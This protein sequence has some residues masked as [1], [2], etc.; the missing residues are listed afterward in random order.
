MCLYFSSHVVYSPAPQFFLSQLQS[1]YH[2]HHSNTAVLV[3]ITSDSY[4]AEATFTSKPYLTCPAYKPWFSRLLG[5]FLL[6]FFLH[7]LCF[8]FHFQVVHFTLSYPILKVRFWQSSLLRALKMLVTT[9]NL[10]LQPEPLLWT[11]KSISNWEH[12]ISA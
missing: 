12:S 11:P 5:H 4:I 7:Y 10:Y 3:K 9:F 2:P 6:L 8:S 1:G